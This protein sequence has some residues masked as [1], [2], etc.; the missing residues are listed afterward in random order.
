MN[1]GL[2]RF[3]DPIF[4]KLFKIRFCFAKYSEM[5]RFYKQNEDLSDLF[6]NTNR[7]YYLCAQKVSL[8]C[9]R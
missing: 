3:L 1:N 2:N 4:T 8:C 5:R 7:F 9:K 6:L